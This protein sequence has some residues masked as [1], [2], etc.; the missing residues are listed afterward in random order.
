[1]TRTLCSG[2]CGQVTAALAEPVFYISG[3]GP[4]KGLRRILC[5]VLA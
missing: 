2:L 4:V 5:S 1:M 3:S